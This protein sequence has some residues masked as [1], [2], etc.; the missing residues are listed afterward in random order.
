MTTLSPHTT[1]NIG[2]L[3]PADMNL[4]GD[5]GNVLALAQ[6]C[7]WRNINVTVNPIEVGDTFSPDQYDLLFMGGGQDTQQHRIERD[8]VT[9]K[10]DCLHQAANMSV[11]ILGVCGGY[12]LLGHYFDPIDG[13]RIDGIGL[14]DVHTIGGTQRLIGNVTAKRPDGTILVG[15]EN[16]S[17]Q[18]FIGPN[19]SPLATVSKGN[20][21]NA[22]DP[23]EGAQQGTVYG[24]YLH[25]SLLP[26]NPAFADELILKALQRRYPDITTLPQ[27]DDRLA[28]MAHHQAAQRPA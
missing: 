9:V 28:E 16:H 8:F 6:R 5:R 23:H 24:T 11:V 10:K 1:F 14:L 18:T 21:N 17:G 2:H 15:F 26:K 13:K 3:Y 4:Y 7:R 19:A 25:G 27:L 22:N 20:G 12:Q